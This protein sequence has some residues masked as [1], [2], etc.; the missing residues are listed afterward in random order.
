[1]PPTRVNTGKAEISSLGSQPHFFV[2]V[3]VLRDPVW[4]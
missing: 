4:K 3:Q 1:M 2:K